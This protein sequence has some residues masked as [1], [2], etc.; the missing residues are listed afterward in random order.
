MDMVAHQAVGY[1]AQTETVTLLAHQAQ[2][3]MPV[4]VI[5]EDF[6]GTN[7][8]LG[9]V[10]WIIGHYYPCHACHVKKIPYNI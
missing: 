4:V 1:K 9:Y 10:M 2:V 7:T 6:H 8:A 5:M 3:L